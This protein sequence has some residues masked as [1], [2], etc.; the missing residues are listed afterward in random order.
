MEGAAA[1][2]LVDLRHAWPMLLVRAVL[3][4]A[5]GLVAL[6]WPGITTIVLA[7]LV[8]A[9]AVVTGIGE[10]LA[11][12]RTL[13]TERRGGLLLAGLLSVVAGVLILGGQSPAR[14]C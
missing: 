12:V 7:I 3:A 14:S 5:L 6:T 1:L 2:L 9:W 13:R 11:A 10:I 4:V 8:G